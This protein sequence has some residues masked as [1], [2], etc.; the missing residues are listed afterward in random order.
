ML[1]QEHLERGCVKAGVTLLFIAQETLALCDE[2]QHGVPKDRR[3]DIT[4]DSRKDGGSISEHVQTL[5]E[6]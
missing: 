5:L 6:R 2:C 1:T 4:R 3:H